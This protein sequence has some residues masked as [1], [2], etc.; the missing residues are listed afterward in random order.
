[1]ADARLNRQL[2]QRLAAASGGRVFSEAQISSLPAILKAS[3]PTAQ[4]T[5][6]DLWHTGWSFAAIVGLLAGEWILRRRWGLR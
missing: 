3:V 4:M 2:L 5:R 1:M 6:R